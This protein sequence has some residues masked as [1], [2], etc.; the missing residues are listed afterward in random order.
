MSFK[1]QVGDKVRVKSLPC[2]TEEDVAIGDIAIVVEVDE[3]DDCL[4]YKLSSNSW[5]DWWFSEY[6]LESHL[7]TRE[8]VIEE[9]HNTQCKLAELHKLLET[10]A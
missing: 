2:G 1:Y 3:D 10:F 8:D 9:I 6:N 4:T 5:S 7:K